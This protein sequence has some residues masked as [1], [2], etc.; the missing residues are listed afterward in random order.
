MSNKRVTSSRK[1]ALITLSALQNQFQG[2]RSL[3]SCVLVEGGTNFTLMLQVREGFQGCSGALGSR[4]D[5][6]QALFLSNLGVT[7]L[8][9]V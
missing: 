8:E 7:R 3:C 9:L 1:G 2:H 6:G 4:V 5:P